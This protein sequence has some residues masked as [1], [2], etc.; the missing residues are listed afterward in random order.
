MS[1]KLMHGV[2]ASITASIGSEFDNPIQC[3][4]ARSDSCKSNVKEAADS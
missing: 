2:L 3:M 4:N 1:S